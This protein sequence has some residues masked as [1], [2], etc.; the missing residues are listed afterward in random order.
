MYRDAVRKLMEWK[1][2]E[3]HRPLIIRGA[4][5]VGKT[6]LMKE[7]GR[8]EY[9]KVAYV[10]FDNNPR[11]DS[12]FKSGM[13][14]RKLVDGLNIEVGFNIDPQNTLLIFDEIQENHFALTSLKYFNENAPEYDII[15][16]GSL[17][18]VSHHK[19]TGFPVGK[20][21][22]LNLYP[23]SFREFLRALGEKQLLK[24]IDENNFE[25]QRVFKGEIVNL[26]RRYCYVGGM[27]RA[28]E[29]FAEKRDY[30]IV[31][32]IQKNILM[33][34]EEDFSKHIPPEQVERT[35]LLWNAIPSQLIKENKK[36]VYGKIKQGARAKDFEIA[37]NWLIDAGLVHKVLRVSEPKM[38]LKAYEDNSCYKLFLL[39]VGLLAAMT[40]LNAQS[41][42][43]NDKLFNDYNGALTEQYVLQSL[44]SLDCLP[45]FYWASNRAELDFIIQVRNQIIPIE[46]KATINLQAKSLKSFRQKYAPKFSVRTS[47]ADFEKNDGLFNIPLFDIRNIESVIFREETKVNHA[48]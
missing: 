14:V 8:R 22:Y 46:A 11:L 17:L 35:R 43:E 26:L 34:Y 48:T 24:I 10:S 27:P 7:F 31:R 23:L 39:D 3:K 16:A 45:I 30:N 18:G 12:L 25:M 6:W 33:D 2:S 21:E 13:D 19:G 15:A 47:L 36:C 20:V 32:K 42:L 28:V 40:D 9:E 29:S 38:P 44:M 37:L 1:K 5:Q 41:L 4:R